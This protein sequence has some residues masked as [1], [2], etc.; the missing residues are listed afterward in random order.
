MER[1]KITTINKLGAEIPDK[2]PFK[3]SSMMVKLIINKSG[4]I[5]QAPNIPCLLIWGV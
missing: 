2:A 4:L 1:C 3:T 5:L